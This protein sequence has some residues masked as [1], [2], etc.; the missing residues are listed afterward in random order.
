MASLLASHLD[1]V[2]K[3]IQEFTSPSR[4]LDEGKEKAVGVY[5]C[6]KNTI[7]VQSRNGDF[8]NFSVKALEDI[9]PIYSDFII[10]EAIELY[11]MEEF[12]A[13]IRLL[14]LKDEFLVY[15]Y[16]IID[17]TI[18]KFLEIN[19]IPIPEGVIFGFKCKYVDEQMKLTGSDTIRAP[20]EIVDVGNNVVPSD[21]IGRQF[22]SAEKLHRAIDTLDWRRGKP[23][24]TYNV[25]YGMN[26]V[27][28]KVVQLVKNINDSKLYTVYIEL[29]NE[30]HAKFLKDKSLISKSHFVEYITETNRLIITFNPEEHFTSEAELTKYSVGLLSSTMQK[31]IRH[32]R[33]SL[34][35]L[36]ETIHKLG[37]AKPYNLP[38][39]QYLK[40]SGCRQLFWRSFI[41]IIEDFRYF[42]VKPNQL[43]IFDLLTFAL[44]TNKEPDFNITPSLLEKVKQLMVEVASC[45]D[46]GDY[47][48]WRKY[49][50]VEPKFNINQSNDL[51]TIFLADH[52]MPKMSG[53][54]IMIKKY[55]SMLM[56]DTI[57]PLVPNTKPIECKKCVLGMTPKYT[58]VDIHCYPNMILKLQASLREKLTTQECSSLVWELSS[59]F[60]NRKT[61]EFK[62]DMFSG[63]NIKVISEIQKDYW[64]EYESKLSVIK[65]TSTKKMIKAISNIELSQYDKRVL[66]L[67]L[68]GSKFKVPAKKSGEK[69]LEVV[70]S[71]ED[72]HTHGEPF[73]IKYVNSEEYIS[74]HSNDYTNNI[75]RVW[76]YLQTNRVTISLSDCLLGYR[77]RLN[78]GPSTKSTTQD[79]KQ[80]TFGLDKDRKPNVIDGENIIYALEW[81]DGDNCVEKIELENYELPTTKDLYIIQNILRINSKG[82]LFDCNY[83]CRNSKNEKM[84]NIKPLLKKLDSNVRDWFSNI[85][86]KMATC[87][88]NIVEISQVTRGGDKI[89]NSVDYYNEGH[90]WSL[91]NLLK[92][93]YPKA[94][95]ISGDLKYKLNINEPQYTKLIEDIRFIVFS[96]RHHER[97]EEV[98]DVQIKTNL[99]PHQRNTVDFIMKNIELGKRGFGDASNVGAGKTLSALAT[100][101]EIYKYNKETKG[102]AL[103]LLPTEKLYKTWRDEINKHF[104]K[105]GINILEQQANGTVLGKEGSGLNI[106]ITTMGRNREHLISKDWLFV[107]IDECLTVQ[108]KE[109][110]QTM[111]AWIQTIHSKYGVLLLSATFF[112]TR[113]D[114]LLYMLK[115]LQCNL[116]ETKEYLD[117]ILTDSIKVHLPQ[118]KRDWSEV[119]IREKLD[120]A[121]RVQYDNILKS[122]L[123]NE[124]KFIRLQKFIHENVDYINIFKKYIG[125]LE[126]EDSK[127]KLLIYAESKAEA[128]TISKSIGDVGLYPDISKKHV[129]V[130][131]ANGTYGLNDLVGFNRIISRPPEPDKLPQMK[132]RLD[133]PGQKEDKLGIYYLVLENTIEEAKYLRIDLCNRF[134]SNHIMPLGDFYSMAL[135]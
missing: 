14:H 17:Y 38:E 25:I 129:V 120:D 7:L 36:E 27:D 122:E 72:Y 92:Y 12:D 62:Q 19:K 20:V 67:K 113:F 111:S 8:H 32:G 107:V 63:N 44:I 65:E 84:I 132:G 29:D 81:F 98:V 117:T 126:K 106:F 2:I 59:K 91:L 23:P 42:S 78:T 94:I 124:V 102:Y 128:E 4:R 26:I 101:L 6:S 1:T 118:V 121:K 47:C 135:K 88:D 45:D 97:V 87:T 99:W 90:F 123:S 114:K 89:D 33:C 9:K 48:E 10:L 73:K 96:H 93:C 54:G 133:R 74:I 105:G 55:F 86:V 51:N 30:H 16:D 109:A 61:Q 60:N 56:K 104:G 115:M 116:P 50:V 69:V 76:N 95:N 82:N 18:C 75:T 52:F 85:L 58:G 43:S 13:I 83:Y 70:F 22:E 130:S 125:E 100:I 34:K 66:F 71:Y 24:V 108:N 134:Y 11:K 37:T 53:D 112:R 35:I 64:D 5:G 77:W 21:W 103:V 39:Q 110:L 80:I 46:S 79:K 3:Q 127:V 131:Y 49:L 28:K 41:T 31:C 68:V 40:V 57:Q 15:G 119:V